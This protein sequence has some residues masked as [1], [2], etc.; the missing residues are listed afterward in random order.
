MKRIKLFAILVIF[1]FSTLNSSMANARGLSQAQLDSLASQLV[2]QL[3]N[4]GWKFVPD[5]FTGTNNIYADF[6]NRD[7]NSIISMNDVILIILNFNGARFSAAAS[8]PHQRGRALAGAVASYRYNSGLPDYINTKGSI[9]SKEISIGRKSKTV[10]VN[11]Q[12]RIEESNIHQPSSMARVTLYI[13]T[14]DHSTRLVFYNMNLDGD[15]QGN[16]TIF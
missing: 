13:N 14:V 11:L 1:V 16:I 12:Y 9:V 4:G 5:S 15:M 7:D 2:E 3:E 6:L 8:T 10:E